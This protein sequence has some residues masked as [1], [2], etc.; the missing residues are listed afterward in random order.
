VAAGYSPE[1][2]F[3]RAALLWSVLGAGLV[4]GVV[5]EV[6]TFL[7]ARYGPSG[8]GGDGPAWSLRGNGALII[9]FG[10]GPAVIAGGW[11]SLVLHYRSRPSG[12]RSQRPLWQHI[13]AMFVFV[14]ALIAGFYVAGLV[15][16]AR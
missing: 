11:T 13:A 3:A 14:P 4:A 1:R 12:Q 7:V 9:P 5:L 8:G 15:L 2:M 16:P 10:L 6:I